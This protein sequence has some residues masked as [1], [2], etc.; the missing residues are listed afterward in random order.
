M[1]LC[2]DAYQNS[3]E[4]RSGDVSQPEGQAP[5][6]RALGG[7]ASPR[8]DHLQKR[9]V[10]HPHPGDTFSG[11]PQVLLVYAADGGVL[12]GEDNDL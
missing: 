9:L 6:H 7:P 4:T 10:P 8:L 3:S 1:Q 11:S 12:H 2:H 5:C